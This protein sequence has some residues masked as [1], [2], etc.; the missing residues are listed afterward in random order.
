MLSLL[1]NSLNQLSMS[2][3]HVFVVSLWFLGSV[4]F[5]IIV[6]SITFSVVIVNVIVIVTVIANVIVITSLCPGLC[7]DESMMSP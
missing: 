4:I 5:T 3:H 6:F 2:F 1:L 7:A